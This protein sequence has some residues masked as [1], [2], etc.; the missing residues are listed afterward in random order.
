M[1]ISRTVAR[2]LLAS[3]FL[4]G[5]ISTLRNPSGAAKKAEPVTGPLVRLGQRA[6]LPISHDPEMLVRINAG[7][8]IAA[9]LCLAT[10]RWPRL[11]ASVLATSLVPTTLAGHAF[12]NESDP[13]VRRQ[14][15]IQLAKN[16][17]LLGGLLIAAGDTDG[18]PGV[19]WLAKHTAADVRRDLDHA[20]HTA[21]LE[22]KVAALGAD[23]GTAAL[24]ASVGTALLAAGQHARE[25]LIDA[26]HQAA[27]S[28]TTQHLAE[29][30]GEVAASLK[31]TAQEKGPVVAA[32]AREHAGS[33]A[34]SAAARAQQARTEAEPVVQELSKQARRKAKHA[35]KQA[36]PVVA[37]L[38]KEARKKAEKART[39]A[40][41]QAPVIA[42]AAREQAQAAREQAIAAGER[43][44]A[45]LA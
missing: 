25:A 7:V 41:K 39:A 24:G 2:P 34:A 5:P 26:A 9:G 16:L 21:R 36:A 15:Q 20:A 3:I 10:G 11:A 35:R 30:A 42:A 27:A 37:D 19:A 44:R 18:K 4:V 22:T 33:L 1:S 12:W 28:E 31:E 13:D 29:R 32:A 14:Q 23:R 17:S 43:A 8:Q 6:G 40:Q 38:R 45:R